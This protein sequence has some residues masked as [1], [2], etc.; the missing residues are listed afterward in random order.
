[1][2]LY[3]TPVTGLYLVD[4]VIYL[5]REGKI[6]YLLSTIRHLI[7][8]SVALATIPMAIV[9]RVTR[10]SMLEV[11]KQD[12]I[13]TARAAGIPERRVIFRYALRNALLPVITVIGLEFGLLLSGAILTETVFAWPGIGKW[14]YN[15]IEARD[16]PAVQGGVIV[17]ATTF[18]LINLV[19]DLL[20]SLVNPKIRL[21]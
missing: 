17:I 15:A 13:K 16:Y 5:F 18:V 20:Y 3:F 7:L 4:S 2:R 12:Y 21:S 9:A 14:L 19:V 11:L 1:M 10:S 8:P 6:E